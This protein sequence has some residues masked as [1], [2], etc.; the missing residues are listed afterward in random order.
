MTGVLAECPAALIRPVAGRVYLH[1]GELTVAA[2]PVLM[3]AI[4]GSCVAVCL[5]DPIARVGGLNHFL[6]PR[7]PAGAAS[8][9]FGDVAVPWLIRA[10]ADLGAD[11]R[12]LRARVFGGAC[13][14]EVYRDTPGH[15]GRQNVQA[16]LA[17]LDA[18][19]VPVE[20]FHIGGNRARRVFFH[21]H[22]GD[23]VVRTL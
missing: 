17:C 15:V 3:T 23:L 8:A 12:R 16:A 20:S 18:A 6:L 13:A 22:S 14:L 19:R 2:E 1:P 7:A 10:M 21:A 11:V 4:L 9:R 5:Y